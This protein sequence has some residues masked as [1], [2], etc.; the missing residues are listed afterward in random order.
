VAEPVAGVEERKQDEHATEQAQQFSAYRP[1]GSDE[2][3]PAM[4]IAM[5][6]ILAAA[7]A[8]VRRRHRQR[9]GPEPALSLLVNSDLVRRRLRRQMRRRGR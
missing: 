3:P 1:A 9:R 8:T 7:G 4:A 5:A 6:I 2:L